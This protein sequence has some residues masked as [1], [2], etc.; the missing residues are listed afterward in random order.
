MVEEIAQTLNPDSPGYA[1][2]FKW[3][4]RDDIGLHRILPATLLVYERADDDELRNEII[5]FW[6][7]DKIEVRKVRDGL[8]HVGQLQS[9]PFRAPVA[10]DN[11]PQQKLRF[12]LE[13]I[14]AAGYRGWVILMDEIELVANYSWLQ[15]ARSYA[16][17]TRWMGQAAD[18]EYSG[19]ILVG[20]L[21][22][23]F[24]EEVLLKKEDLDKV[25]PRLRARGRDGD[26]LTAA[27]AETGMRLITDV[28]H[29]L[30]APDEALLSNLYYQLKD[31]HS[32]AYDWN[33]PDISREIGL[34]VRRA[35]RPFV[36]R[37]INEWDLRRLY[38]ESEPDIEETSLTFTYE[39]DPTLEQAHADDDELQSTKE[40][41]GP[42]TST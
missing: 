31:I 42:P 35:I 6:S 4:N 20:T 3:V 17:L 10:R 33:A 9:Y 26:D 21:T 11:M 32:Q 38:P 30:G 5:W 27:R 29:L 8:R 12:V 19:L 25:G 2:F 34:G 1:G 37:W 15:R 16:E 39:E 41:D 28:K 14:K 36:R 22:A 40:T 13:L 18:E 23:D 7:G 24:A